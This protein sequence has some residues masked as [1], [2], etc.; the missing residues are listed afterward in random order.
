MENAKYVASIKDYLMAGNPCL[1]LPT[2]EE[3]V[4]ERRVKEAILQLIS[5]NS[6]ESA[7]LAIWKITSGMRLYPFGSYSLDD[8]KT[9]KG[10]TGPK[11]LVTALQAVEKTTKSMVAVF[12]H[13]RHY[14]NSPQVIQ[15]IIDTVNKARYSYSTLIFVGPYLELPPELHDVVTYCECPLPTRSELESEFTALADG[16]KDELKLDVSLPE[17]KEI[18]RKSA[19]AASGL[20]TLAAENAASLSIA[21]AGTFD[22]ELIQQQKEQDIKKSD[23]LE[24]IQTKENLNTV[25]GFD[26]LKVWLSKRK[27]GF[28]DEAVTYGLKWPKGILLAGIAGCLTGDTQ[29]M[30]RKP[31]GKGGK[32]DT[33]ESLFYRFNN[34][35]VEGKRLGKVK[36]AV[37]S[38]EQNR[39]IITYSFNDQNKCLVPNAI[40][41]VV[42]SGVKPVYKITTE[43]GNTIKA[44]MDHKFLTKDGNF[45]PLSALS[46]ND[47]VVTKDKGLYLED[48]RKGRNKNRS[49]GVLTQVGNHPNARVKIINKLSYTFH[50]MCRLVVEARMNNLTLEDFLFELQGDISHLNFLPADMEVHHK[51]QNRLNNKLDNLE[52]LTKEEHARLHTVDK[53]SSL[54]KY[55]NMAKYQKITSIEYIGEEDTYDIQM[56]DPYHNFVAN[57]FVVHNSGKTLVSKSI[58]NYFNLPLLRL[59]MGKVFSSLVG[60]S[61]ARLRQALKVTEAVSPCV[62]VCDELEKSLAGGQGSNNLDSGVT[63]RIVATLLTWR[64][65]TTAP[66]FMV[67]TVNDPR[68]LPPM[69]YRKGRFD[70][71]WSVALPNE[72]ERKVI[73]EIHLKKRKRDPENFDTSLLSLKSNKFTGAEIESCIEDAMFSAFYE[74]EEVETRHILDSLQN[75]SP[76]NVVDTEESELLAKWMETYAR[77]V[78]TQ[79]KETVT[80]IRQLTKKGKK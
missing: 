18:I 79:Q 25:G 47:L 4:A 46:V 40:A 22:Y 1:F 73:F 16:Y 74:G 78:S 8:S 51:D 19:I 67:A 2:I 59:D 76:Q 17:T 24:F 49:L 35:V 52:V 9:N 11:E 44:T 48:F 70:E 80:N 5:D 75:T 57:G 42:Y 10:E 77:P 6:R 31:G 29:I 65:E 45:V 7:D 60:S 28:T 63:A 61:E 50:P 72:Q 15:Q 38:W 71:I 53:E 68:S 30:I 36:K 21:V 55:T 27:K 14:L 23:I 39:K 43:Y 12:Y 20:T 64:Q 34:R 32:Y 3:E 13:I 56:D 69:V 62:L 33:L 66:V 26:E 37:R 41:G 58:A 54:Y